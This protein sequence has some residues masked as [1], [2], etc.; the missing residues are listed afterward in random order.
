[1]D[2][3]AVDASRMAA[4]L[5]AGKGLPGF[6]DGVSS[7][8]AIGEGT[9]SGAGGVA[10]GGLRRAEV[11]FAADKLSAPLAQLAFGYSWDGLTAAADFGG[12]DASGALPAAGALAIAVDRFPT[13][14]LLRAVLGVLAEGGAPGGKARKA[15]PRQM[16]LIAARTLDRSMNAAR[17][18]FLAA[19][20][21]VRIEEMSVTAADYDVFAKGAFK[22]SPSGWGGAVDL[23]VRDLGKLL[24]FADASADVALTAAPI[25]GGLT[26]IAEY[27]REQSDAQGRKITTFDLRFEPS[28]RLLVNGRDPKQATVARRKGG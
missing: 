9:L 20:T 13:Q 15:D 5:K 14:E 8:V 19:K 3:R 21:E 27:G 24:A 4:A 2:W 10:L 25:P 1:M 23:R 18:A 7:R 17:S 28:G 16:E 11:R 26:G 22:P 12:Q 6:A